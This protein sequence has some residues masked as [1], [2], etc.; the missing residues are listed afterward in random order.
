MNEEYHNY[1]IEA[2]K[3]PIITISKKDNLTQEY[4]KEVNEYL[5]NLSDDEFKRLFKDAGIEL[6]DCQIVILKSMYSESEIKNIK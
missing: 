3:N 5:Q 6:L 2:L 1:L 4:K